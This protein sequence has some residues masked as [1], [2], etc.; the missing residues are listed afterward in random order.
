MA[1]TS[2]DEDLIASFSSHLLVERGL[3]VNTLE[4]YGRDLGKYLEFI[5]SSGTSLDTAADKDI[6]AFLVH[7]RNEGLG[8]RSIARYLA[9]IKAFYRFLVSEGLLKESPAAGI[10][11]PRM[12]KTLPDAL[13][14]GDCDRLLGQP[15][16]RTLIGLRDKAMIELLYATGLRVSELI[17]LS[18]N[19]CNFITG[20]L[21]ALGKGNKER[22]IPLGQVAIKYLK[23]YLLS[24][25]PKWARS[26]SASTLFISRTGKGLTRQGFWKIIKRYARRSGIKKAI[27]PHTLRHS[28]AT[29]LLERGADL[30]SIQIFLGHA[31]ISTTQIYTHVARKRLKDIHE[32]YHPRG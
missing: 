1:I 4:A 18:I 6:L 7:L 31:D 17:S 8:S 27:T 11:T 16:T 32:K 28:F 23:E 12:V 30:R 9:S 20:C 13:S 14:I 24:C 10:R 25:R 5:H 19:D 2:S 21:L 26:S 3:A 22:L 29:H 15:D